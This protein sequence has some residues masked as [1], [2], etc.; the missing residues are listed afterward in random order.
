MKYG[1]NRD[2][3]SNKFFRPKPGRYAPTVSTT[4]ASVLYALSPGV[5][6]PA[7]QPLRTTLAQFNSL[8]TTQSSAQYVI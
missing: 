2:C 4:N 6:F 1:E 8:R 7:P 3:K 5:K